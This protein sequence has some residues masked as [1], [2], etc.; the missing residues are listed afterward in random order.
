MKV[1]VTGATGY[2]GG[3]LVPELLRAGHQ[4]KVLV[5]HA[6]RI[7][8]RAWYGE[9]E[10]AEGDL[11]NARGLGS[12]GEGVDA[13]YYLVHSMGA[14]EG[15]AA[16]DRAFAEVFAEALRDVGK[17]VYLGG[18]LPEGASEHLRSRAE[19]GRIL[20][21]RLPTTEF[22]AGPIIGSGS[23]SF[24]MVRYLT[25][26]LPVMIAP[27]WVSNEVQPIGID[28]VL[29]Y[30][31]LA[32][33]RPALGV[34]EIGA[35][36]MTFRRMME[37]YA[38]VRGLR[39]TIIPVPVLAPRLAAHWVGL[40]T[41]IGNSLAIPLI[42]G[43]VTPVL[44]DTTRARQHF[45]EIRPRP[46]REAVAAA[47]RGVERGEVE[48]RW[49]GGLQ[50]GEAH[51]M[52]DREGMVREERTIL[53]DASPDRVFAVLASLGGDRGWL[54]WN[55]AWRFRGFLDRIVGGPGLRRG[56]RHPTHLLSGEAVDFWRVER[57]EPGSLLRLRAEMKVPGAA[58]L[59]WRIT[60]EGAGCRVAQTA[61]FAPTGAAGTLY[62]YLLYPVHGLIF[63]DLIHAIKRESESVPRPRRAP[64]G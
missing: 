33:E 10:V 58:W 36:V 14:G 45:P 31:R 41:P 24:E 56:R 16:R 51:A 21:D 54:V 6:D 8:D 64:A 39:R 29:A 28:D 23:A 20:R 63:D 13:A 4:V 57:V 7:R 30:L 43:I 48:T 22:R 55:A 59:E 5:R 25:E 40:V 12:L 32:L 2:I 50:G 42:Q 26:R 49:S 11:S 18:L 17:A 47:L 52:T 1:L 62:W 3:R 38:G 34:V 60:P 27:R 53:V 46:Y 9:V 19:V 44:A 61:L 35:D 15:Y 37:E